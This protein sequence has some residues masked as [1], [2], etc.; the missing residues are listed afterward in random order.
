MIF[1]TL[2]VSTIVVSLFLGT[3]FIAMAGKQQLQGRFGGF[4]AA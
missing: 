4:A 1:E 3:V 2:A